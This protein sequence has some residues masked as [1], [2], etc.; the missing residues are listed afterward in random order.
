MNQTYKATLSPYALPPSLPSWGDLEGCS[1]GM[2]TDRLSNITAGYLYAPFG[3]I[4]QEHS[5]VDNR[6]PKYAFNA[7]E[8]DEENGMYY[9]SAR[10]YAPPTFI[11]RDPMFEKY[12]SISPYTYCKN[13]PIIFIDPDG[14]RVFAYDKISKHYMK[15]YIKDQFG[16]TKMFRFTIN[17]ELKINKHQFNKA[18][19]HANA[20]QKILLQG[21]CDAINDNNVVKVKVNENSKSFNFSDP[22]FIGYNQ[23]GIPQYNNNGGTVI[24]DGAGFTAKAPNI[25]YY[26]IGI[27]NSAAENETASTDKL[28]RIGKDDYVSQTT[29]KSPSSVFM[30]ELLDEFLNFYSKGNVNTSSPQIDKVSYHNA[31]LQNKG[32]APRNGLDHEK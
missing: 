3:E 7:K 19:T 5:A 24:R 20:D 15:S 1:T 28:Q 32:L 10:Y 23:D 17:N 9:Y 31:A 29:G 21:L 26:M 27:N 13:N 2:V 14:E 25:S 22:Q 4:L 6:I 18:M 16:T 8:F 11:S 12:P 30:H